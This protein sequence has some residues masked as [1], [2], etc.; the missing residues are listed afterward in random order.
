MI[1]TLNSSIN[2]SSVSSKSLKYVFVRPMFTYGL[3]KTGCLCSS[4]N[5]I[6]AL[7]GGV[8]IL[9]VEFQKTQCRPVEFKKCSCR[10]VEFKKCS[11][12]PVEFKKCSCRP[13]EFKKCSC[14]PVESKK[15]SC[16]MSLRPKI[17]HVALSILGV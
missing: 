8:L 7:D 2:L 5:L 1:E 17:P 12:R 15:C 13:V 9:H 6:G 16:P 4:T 11:C 14:R 10:P 3:I